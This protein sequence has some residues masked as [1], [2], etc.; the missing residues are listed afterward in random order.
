MTKVAA[1]SSTWRVPVGTSTDR[2]TFTFRNTRTPRP[3]DG[4]NSK[5]VKAAV[6]S[7][8]KA[9]RAL[10]HTRV[11]TREIASALNLRPLLVEQAVA[12]LRDEGVKV[13]K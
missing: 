6:L 7:H 3:Q 10:G 11:N 1:S 4:S 5:A 12:Q 8:I 13:A 2:G 9:L